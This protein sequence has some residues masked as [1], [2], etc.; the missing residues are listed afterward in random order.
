MKYCSKCGTPAEDNQNFCLN[1]GSRLT[2]PMAQA[3]ADAAAT[4]ATTAQTAQDQ[5]AAQQQQTAAAAQT[6]QE[7]LAAQQAAAAQTAAAVAQQQ[8]AAADAAAQVAATAEAQQAAAE[9]AAQAKAAAE[10]QAKAAVQAQAQQVAAQAQPVQ[11]AVP[12]GVVPQVAQP[13]APMA[14]Q[15]AQAAPAADGTK[16]K[17]GA[18]KWFA[19]IGFALV[20]IIL[21]IVLLLNVFGSSFQTPIKKQISAMNSMST[22]VDDYFACYPKMIG[23][24]Y[25]EALKTTKEGVKLIGNDTLTKIVDAID[26]GATL[27]SVYDDYE[28]EVGKNL[29][30]SYDIVEKKTLDVSVLTATAN[31]YKSIANTLKSQAESLTSGNSATKTKLVNAGVKAKDAN[32]YCDKVV[33]VINNAYKSLMEI[34][35]KAITEGY[36]V[37]FRITFKGDKDE[38][39]DTQTVRVLKINGKWVFDASTSDSQFG[40][41]FIND[42]VKMML[43][44]FG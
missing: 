40:A 41:S 32:D 4:A 1:C 44:N 20:A 13:V 35:E 22:K 34:D 28:K 11:A 2:A 39:F 27:S 7:Q 42:M 23:K 43:L 5:L 36:D 38:D 29:K 8:Q 33:A 37:T 30:F 9:A 14:A 16:K 26:F 25:D 3:A 21:L 15:P 17:S 19:I 12:A 24:L 10:A 6:A 31:K 18:G